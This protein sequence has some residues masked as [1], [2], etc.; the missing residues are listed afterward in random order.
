V[1]LQGVTLLASLSAAGVPRRLVRLARAVTVL[2]LV[3]CAATVPMHGTGPS[4]ASALLD[5]LLV[6]L[7]PVAIAW[8][9]VRRRDVDVHVVLGALCIY[10]PLGMFW[11]FVFAAVGAVGSGPFF[12]PPSHPTSADYRYF[13][14]VTLTTVGYGDLTV[15]GNVGRALASLDAVLGQ[16]PS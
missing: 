12:A 16:S 9:I 6:A 4:G 10:V 8:P 15:G 11:A 14:F 7:A 5:A 3:A 1:L 13:A 2:A